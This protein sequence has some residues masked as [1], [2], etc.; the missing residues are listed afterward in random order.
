MFV[1]EADIAIAP[2]T[3]TSERDR[4]V[5]FSIP[6]M[7]L[8][9]SIM[10]KKPKKIEMSFFDVLSLGMWAA[11]L[12]AYFVICLFYCFV[13]RFTRGICKQT[14]SIMAGSAETFNNSTLV[15]C[16]GC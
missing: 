6:Y 1:K 5:D 12:F 10:I 15:L 4:Y 13:G 2:L 8:G 3:I 7:T 14:N 11:I 16:R 9:I